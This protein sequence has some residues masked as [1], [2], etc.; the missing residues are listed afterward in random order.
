MKIKKEYIALI[1]VIVALSAYILLKSGD[2][3]H[4]ELPQLEKL[5]KDMISKMVF[6]HGDKSIILE[7]QD[8]KWKI[9]PQGYPADKAAVDRMLESVSGFNITTLV[10]ESGNYSVYDL[11]GDK[12]VKLEV[13]SGPDVKL[14]IDIGKTAT[15]HRHTFVRIE[16]ENGIY[17]AEGNI[18]NVFEVEVEK[19]RD[20]SVL[21]FNRDDVAS[22]DIMSEEGTLRLDR[23]EQ[24]AV[25]MP[26]GDGEAAQQ[27]P[28]V[29]WKSEDGRAADDKVV[30]QMLNALS[31]LR[32][33]GYA[34]GKTKDDYTAPI[35]T[36]V[37]R[38]GESMTLS[39]Y[40]AEGEIYPGVSSQ[41]DYPFLL[42]KWRVDQ[43][44]KSPSDMIVQSEDD[45]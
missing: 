34:E 35:Y 18:R 6:S 25:N 27:A 44:M 17:Q 3:T 16:G 24:P 21:S 5:E 26:A 38:A 10:A 32:C 19:L 39:I 31:S 2:R 1:A 37:V 45:K 11:E 29:V 15:T 43:I 41:N 20:K 30:S 42:P 14:A 40:A 7:R 9:R 12:R 22:I 36:L 28:A 23:Q 13:Y 4:Y 33:D 8:E